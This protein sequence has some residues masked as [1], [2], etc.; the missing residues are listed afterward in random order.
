MF[1]DH[2]YSSGLNSN[3]GYQ[4]SYSNQSGLPQNSSF[5]QIGAGSFP[6]QQVF[7]PAQLQGNAPQR[8][9]TVEE[10]LN[11]TLSLNA[12]LMSEMAQLRQQLVEEKARHS[13]AVEM[14]QH[15]MDTVENQRQ[16][17]RSFHGENIK[18]RREN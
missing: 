12:R 10:M 14:N 9:I 2:G 4:Q 7:Y 16:E 17:L 6:Q 11:N 3:T 18:L 1:P 13:R 8:F 5:V 15:L